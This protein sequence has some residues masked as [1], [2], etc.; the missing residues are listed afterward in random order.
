VT[1]KNTLIL[2]ACVWLCTKSIV[3]LGFKS[4]QVYNAKKWPLYIF[5]SS[6]TSLLPY[7][8]THPTP[9][10][11][12]PVERRLEILDEIPGQELNEEPVHARTLRWVA[13]ILR[14]QMPVKRPK[15]YCVTRAD[16]VILY[17]RRARGE[18]KV[19]FPTRSFYLMAIR[20]GESP[21]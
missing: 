6:P 9:R 5:S 8:H 1:E 10:P 2:C 11:R 18:K 13:N 20:F 16:G 19:F 21:T 17:R 15:G 4:V 3:Y 12:E 14:F 7:I